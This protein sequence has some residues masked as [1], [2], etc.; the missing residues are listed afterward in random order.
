MGPLACRK[1]VTKVYRRGV[2]LAVGRQP[3]KLI[4]TGSIPVPRSTPGSAVLTRLLLV[5]SFLLFPT[6]SRF[7]GAIFEFATGSSSGFFGVLCD[8]VSR[9]ADFESCRVLIAFVSLA[10]GISLP[11]AGMRARVH[12]QYEN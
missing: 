11:L 6:L 1:M 10:L 9:F 2:G 5:F 7:M 4:Y 12:S 8:F 3:S